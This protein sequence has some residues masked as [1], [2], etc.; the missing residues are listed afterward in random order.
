MDSTSGR[1]VVIT[2]AVFL[3][4]LGLTIA[5]HVRTAGATYTNPGGFTSS[6]FATS[7]RTFARFGILQLG[8]VPVDNNPPIG[9]ND[10]YSHWPPLFPA[11]LSISFRL[12]GASETTGHLF[13][14]VV[15][16]LTALL[17]AAIAQDWLGP[18]AG[19]L[20]G[21]FW[22]TMPVVVHYGEVL[23]T[24][25]PAVMLMLLSVWAFQRSRLTLCATAAF[26]GVL[27]SWE[28]AL[29]A[30]ALWAAAIVGRRTS[31]RRI[32]AASTIAILAALV[33]VF[34]VYAL[35]NPA[36]FADAIHTGL[37]R[38]GLAHTYSQRPIVESPESYVGFVDSISLIAQNLPRMLGFFGAGALVML[39][40]SRP[41]GSAPVLYGLG[42]PFVLWAVLMRNHMAVHD[43]EMLIG[44][45]LAA[46]ALAW[47][48]IG[49]VGGQPP[50]RVWI[51]ACVFGALVIA[52]P[53]IL[54]YQR[55]PENPRQ[56]LGFSSGIRD[57]TPQ[58]AIVLSPLVSAIPLYYSERHLVRCIPDEEALA[59][60]LPYVRSQYPAAP[61]Y[62]AT[63]LDAAP[64]VVVK[65][66]Q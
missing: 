47:M 39:A 34:A 43:L 19:A 65:E 15:Q 32:A 49:S 2:R 54:G 9:P 5:A 56:I 20:A 66:L 64:W 22:L 31:D 18:L 36:L 12:F 37:F 4:A 13:M 57:A 59:R 30:P 55:N 63:P 44:A 23:L 48:A 41:K 35:H 52:Q 60:V 51:I 1:S 46:I 53:W 29:L 28:A 62:W 38:M 25:S 26:L 50:R 27:T 3:L 10:S 33:T 8:G 11:A 16:I 24:E 17:V 14:L 61:L 6:V 7:A 58:D 45:P 40:M 21:F 42:A